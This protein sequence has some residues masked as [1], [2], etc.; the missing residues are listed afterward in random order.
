MAASCFLEPLDEKVAH[1]ICTLA[2]VSALRRLPLPRTTPFLGLFISEWQQMKQE[3]AC[4]LVLSSDPALL[5][6][7]SQG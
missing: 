4:C 6:R 5:M 7:L 1:E 3:K 2:G